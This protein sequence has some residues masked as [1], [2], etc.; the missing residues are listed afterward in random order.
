MSGARSVERRHDGNRLQRPDARGGH[1][2][3]RGRSARGPESWSMQKSPMQSL[4]QPGS[5]QGLIIGI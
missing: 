3:P 4:E 2:R 1:G 5:M